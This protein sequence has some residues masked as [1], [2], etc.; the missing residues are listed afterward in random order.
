MGG[1][2]QQDNN[3]FF[4]IRPSTDP[5][6]RSRAIRVRQHRRSA[7]HVRL[8]YIVRRH[9]PAMLGKSALNRFHNLGVAFQVQAEGLR[10]RLSGQ[11]IFGGTE[12]AAE[13]QNVGA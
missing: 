4:S 8:L 3:L 2:G 6:S 11:I 1:T 9:L 10:Y 12:A 7:D 13:K 5:L